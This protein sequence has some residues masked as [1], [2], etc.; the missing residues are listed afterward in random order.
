MNKFQIMNF[1]WGKPAEDMSHKLKEVLEV[2]M[3]IGYEYEFW[4]HNRAYNK[5]G[6][7]L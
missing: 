1:L 3:E 7:F 5:G 4:F 2:G 6:R